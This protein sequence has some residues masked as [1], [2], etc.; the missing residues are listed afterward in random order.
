MHFALIV[1]LCVCLC[2]VMHYFV[3]ISDFL[4]SLKGKEK[5]GR[6]A[7]IVLQMSCYCICSVAF[8]H[9]A[10]GWSAVCNPGIS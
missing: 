8:P 5:S 3:S 9:D 10:V 4:S 2:L 6:L 1:G 7:F